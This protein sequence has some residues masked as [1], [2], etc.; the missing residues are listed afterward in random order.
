ME[1]KNG[2]MD[3]INSKVI[4]TL[5][6]IEHEISQLMHSELRTQLI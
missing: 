6:Y 3:P 1:K 5:Q 2:K 4:K